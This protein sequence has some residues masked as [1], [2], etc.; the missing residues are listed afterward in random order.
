V[1][2]LG[3]AGGSGLCVLYRPVSGGSACAAPAATVRLCVI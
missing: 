1:D 3:G 2:G